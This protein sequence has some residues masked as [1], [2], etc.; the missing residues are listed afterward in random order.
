MRA[1]AGHKVKGG[2]KAPQRALVADG[3]LVIEWPLWKILKSAIRGYIAHEALTRG[4]AIAFY[5]ITSLAPVLLVVVATAGL[6]FQ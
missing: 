3:Q 2:T 1:T 6:V 4:A 5:A